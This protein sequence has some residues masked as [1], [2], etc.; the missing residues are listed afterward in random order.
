MRN[1]TF[2]LFPAIGL[3]LCLNTSFAEKGVNV[4]YPEWFKHSLY[5]LQGDIQDARDA[6]KRGIMLFFSEK[7]CSY[8]NAI[9]E[10]TFKQDD[11]VKRL[12]S[13][14]DVIG[15]EV[16][17]DIE[18]VDTQG[19]THWTKDF[20]IQEK[21]SF[22][23]TMVFYDTAGAKQL[24]LVGYQSPEKF[25]GVLNYLEDERAKS[26]NLRDYLRQQTSSAAKS[27]GQIKPVDLKI[28]RENN[29]PLLVI[30]ES[31]D[32][33]KCLQLRGMLKE[34]VVQSYSQRLAIAYVN[35]DDS[36][37]PITTPEGNSLTGKD[38]ANQLGLIHNPAMVFFNEQG[39]EKLRVDT[40][41]LVD[42]NGKDVSDKDAH[43]LDNLR[44]RLQFFL[45]K[46]YETL[47][48]FQRWRAAQKKSDQ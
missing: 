40:D 1:I 12:R 22:T 18:V 11:I 5:D 26:M 36:S 9:I 30:F 34:P 10:T 41:I 3:L 14:Y 15:L 6:G 32:C 33:R 16:F 47:P 23:P 31:A 44:A 43:I 28:R 45:D 4:V 25:R 39:S 13:G 21:A 7:S 46:G 27:S 24:R 19:K 8:C 37:T 35:S 48:Q 38:W 2:R 20:A 29:K 17:S 42:K